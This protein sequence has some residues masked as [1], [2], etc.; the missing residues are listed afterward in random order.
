MLSDSDGTAVL[1][2]YLGPEVSFLRQKLPSRGLRSCH[3]KCEG[4]CHFQGS[5]LK[6]VQHS[7]LIK[8]RSAILFLFP[9]P[10]YIQVTVFDTGQQSQI[11]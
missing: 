3:P 4:V 9:F 1:F 5:L 10:E 8:I 6:S 7:D 2:I 11:N